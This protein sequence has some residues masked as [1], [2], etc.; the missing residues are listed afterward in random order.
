MRWIVEGML[1]GCP[2]LELQN[3]EGGTQSFKNLNDGHQRQIDDSVL[4][5]IMLR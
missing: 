5:P 4:S 2:W 3:F 1:V